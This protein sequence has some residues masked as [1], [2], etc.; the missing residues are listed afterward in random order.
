MVMTS[1]EDIPELLKVIKILKKLQT[2]NPSNRQEFHSQFAIC[3]EYLSIK[4]EEWNHKELG[5][6]LD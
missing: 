4:N 1:I 5:V 6:M 2:E 3:I